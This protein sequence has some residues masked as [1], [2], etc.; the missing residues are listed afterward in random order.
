MEYGDQ[1][2]IFTTVKNKINEWLGGRNTIDRLM[3]DKIDDFYLS[4]EQPIPIRIGNKTIYVGNM[5]YQN[6]KYFLIQ[7]AKIMSNIGV[8]IINMDIP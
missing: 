7:F 5:V 4:E 8:Q 1:K 2:K 3:K 6:Y